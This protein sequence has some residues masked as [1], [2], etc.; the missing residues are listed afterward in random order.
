MYRSDDANLR[1]EHW[2]GAMVLITESI[3]LPV[4]HHL[5]TSLIK[6]ASESSHRTQVPRAGAFLTHISVNI[7]V[8]EVSQYKLI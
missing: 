7:G 2:G 1:G 3:R 6:T 4:S 5:S 8:T